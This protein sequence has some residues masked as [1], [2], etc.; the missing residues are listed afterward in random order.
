MQDTGDRKARKTMTG[1]KLGTKRQRA[2]WK[3]WIKSDNSTK[4]EKQ[5]HHELTMN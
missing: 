1:D 2:S 4:F 5:L 3:T